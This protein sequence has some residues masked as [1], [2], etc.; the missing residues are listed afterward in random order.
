MEPIIIKNN[1]KFDLDVDEIKKYINKKTKLIIIN[2]PN[3]PSG[4]VYNKLKL[5]GLGKIAKENNLFV[6]SDEV[7]ESI[8][9]DK[10][11]HYSI[12]SE[13]SCFNNIISVFTEVLRLITNTI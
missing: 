4:S 9:F 8:V 12:A 5:K 11:V 6:L 3:N 7:Y 1:G 13:A 2:S 10:N